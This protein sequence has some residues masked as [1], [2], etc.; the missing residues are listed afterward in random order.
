MEERVTENIRLHSKI[1]A[2]EREV[3]CLKSK[4]TRSDAVTQSLNRASN[5]VPYN[6]NIVN[7]PNSFRMDNAYNYGSNSYV[8]PKLEI[9][10]LQ[11]KEISSIKR[12]QWVSWYRFQSDV[13]INH[14]LCVQ[15]A[16]CEKE[17]M[18]FC[19]WNNNYCSFECQ[20]HHW[21]AGHKRVCKR[22]KI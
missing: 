10:T 1:V 9:K 2:L 5:N 20:Q 6:G 7:N 11:E 15:C 14:C 21:H 13:S 22:K 18:Y 17:A 3:E 4:L 8:Q 16:N 19:C 12:T